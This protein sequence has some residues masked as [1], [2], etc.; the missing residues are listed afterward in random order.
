M[1]ANRL[2]RVVTSLITTAVILACSLV[3]GTLTDE[4]T[5]TPEPPSGNGGSDPLVDIVGTWEPVVVPGLTDSKITYLIHAD[6]FGD[7]YYFSTATGGTGSSENPPAEIWRTR[8]GLAWEM[9]GEPG[10]G[11][12]RNWRFVVL[13]WH[14]RLYVLTGHYNDFFS[15][16]ASDDGETFQQ[17]RG[18][19]SEKGYP[20]L[21]VIDDKLFLFIGSHE[22]DGLQAWSSSDGER[23]ERVFEKG[24][25]DPTNADIVDFFKLEPTSLK[26]WSYFGIRNL[27][28]G[29]EI[30]RTKDGLKWEKSATG[31]LDDPSN[32]GFAPQLVFN[33]YLY[34]TVP[35]FNTINSKG[36]NVFRTADGEQWEKVVEDGFGLGEYQATWAWLM[37][38][39]DVLYLLTTNDDPRGYSFT[40]TGF[41]MWKSLDGK[42]W[43]Q[44]GDPGFGNPNNFMIN[45]N[46]IRD[47]FYLGTYNI[48]D[49]NQLWRSTDGEKWELF[50]T[51]SPSETNQ[52]GGIVEVGDSL[53]FN[54]NDPVQGVG[55]WRYGP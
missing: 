49:G 4:E 54:T 40:P 34:V 13:T 27:T 10:M 35:P 19:W 30:W 26:G 36:V 51:A 37:A 42:A 25:D 17:I 6:K 7:Y 46:I 53:I 15:I 11:D 31:G 20:S 47:V 44:V 43:Q 29:G 41:R 9:V 39:H 28:K 2:F 8:D 16:W 14:E 23:F 45:M 1:Q 12:A 18:D 21:K 32:A 5:H 38:Y 52:G 48:K 50:F 3:T 22:E 24:L 55:I 33:D